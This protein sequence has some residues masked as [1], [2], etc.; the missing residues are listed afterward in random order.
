[1]CIFRQIATGA[2]AC[3]VAPGTRLILSFLPLKPLPLWQVSPLNF[4]EASEAYRAVVFTRTVIDNE[5]K[6]AKLSCL[7]VAFY[8]PSRTV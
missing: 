5:K 3:D 1:M 2:A 4:T 6:L 8:L 7:F